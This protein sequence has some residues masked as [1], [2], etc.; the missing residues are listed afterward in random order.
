MKPEAD[1][2]EKENRLK[3]ERETKCMRERGERLN[4]SKWVIRII[5]IAGSSV[6][7]GK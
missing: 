2:D 1:Q 4:Q 7:I 6:V 5:I 3:R